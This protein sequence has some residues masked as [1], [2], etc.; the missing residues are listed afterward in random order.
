MAA[1]EHV[2][3]GVGVGLRQVTRIDHFV[4]D[5][6]SLRL[7]ER[8]GR[9]VLGSQRT[10]RVTA[11]ADTCGPTIPSQP[12]VDSNAVMRTD[13]NEPAAVRQPHLAV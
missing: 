9:A 8:V 5:G 3:V 6:H 1:K 2:D 12:S 10:I 7:I 11:T 4:T 13:K